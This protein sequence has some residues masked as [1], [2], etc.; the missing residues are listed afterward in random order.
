MSRGWIN[1]VEGGRRWP[2]REWVGQAEIALEASGLL[3]PAW[4]C[5]NRDRENDTELRRLLTVSERESNLLLAAKPDAVELDRI[6]ESAANLAVAYLSNPA[7]PMLEQA[8]ALRHELTRRLTLG[9]VRP[10]E[11]SD[12]YVTLGRV[13]GVLAYAALD[14]GRPEFAATHAEVTWRMAEIADDN[15]LRAWTRGTQSLIARYKKR[16]VQAK[17]YVDDGL[18]FAGAGTSEVRLLCGAAQCA[19]N[20][21]DNASTLQQIEVANCARENAGVDTV[22]GIFGFSP[23]KQAYYSA[24]SLMWLPDRPALEVAES[25]AIVAIGA[26]QHEPVER[27]SLD[28]EALAH[29]YL[30]TARLKLGEVEGAMESVRPIMRMPE[31]RQIS[32]IRDRIADLG[33]ILDTARYRAAATTADA[34]EE[35]RA[36]SA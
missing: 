1:N 27:R 15:E 8:G 17:T 20:L 2:A 31:E 36:F 33:G 4:D 13:C 18:R 7:R 16:Y 25:S 3:L 19:A 21:G 24:S 22:E 12:L 10:G 6:S 9:A 30:A 23:A 5:A 35:L 28:D 14:L 11:L 32:W 34:R 29:V 26:W